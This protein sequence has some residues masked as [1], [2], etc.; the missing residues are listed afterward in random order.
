[1]TPAPGHGYADQQVVKVTVAANKL[2]VPG[3]LV[4]VLEC[5]DPGGKAAN[6]P[7]DATSC[8]GT[9]QYA[10][11]ATF[12][13][14]GSVDIPNFRLYELPNAALAEQANSQPACGTAAV[15]CVLYVGMNQNDFTEPKI[16]SAPFVFSGGPK[17]P[18]ATSSASTAGTNP[19]AVAA[20][21]GTTAT[22]MPGGDPSLAF[23][24]PSPLVFVT[25]GA[26]V[27]LVAV[28]TVARRRLRRA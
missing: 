5:A 18:F 28:A 14:D 9:T 26:G 21:G 15:P 7:V 23:T 2:F 3:Q 25:A 6:L 22:T 20:A 8:D 13:R 24:G 10:Q 12:G 1:M 16:F 17:Q 27:T 19:P 4:V 11:T